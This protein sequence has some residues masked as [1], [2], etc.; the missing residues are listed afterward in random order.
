MPTGNPYP[1][2]TYHWRVF[3]TCNNQWSQIASAPGGKPIKWIP[4]ETPDGLNKT[5]TFGAIPSSLSLQVF[6]NG[7][8]QNENDDYT[9]VGNQVTMIIAPATG[10]KLIAYF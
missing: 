5:F 10:D 4:A 9:L 8:L 6:W 7:V 2:N 3:E 1:P